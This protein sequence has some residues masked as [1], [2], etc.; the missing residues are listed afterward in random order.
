MLKCNVTAASR[1]G[2]IRDNN[3]D[4][5]LVGDTF[6]RDDSLSETYE[7]DPSKRFLMALADGMGGHNSGEVASSDVLHNLQFFYSDI[8]SG[9]CAGDFNE[10]IYEWLTSMNNILEAKGRVEPALKDMGTTLVALALYENNFYWMNC[11]D[12]RLYRFRNGKLE[13]LSIDHSLSNLLGE[14]GHSNVITNC[15][16][17]GCDNSYIDIVKCTSDVKV[18]DMFLLCSDGLSDMVSD[19]MIENLL[20]DGADASQLCD[21]AENAGGLDNV[22]VALITIGF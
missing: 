21:E 12:S 8:P 13:Q 2:C 15:I 6:I 18:G 10:V 14:K 3:E 20:N 22:S 9:L 4:M 16:G 19:R 7:I 11:G 5:I 1:V 17:G